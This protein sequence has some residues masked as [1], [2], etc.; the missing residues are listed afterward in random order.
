MTWNIWLSG[1]K[2]TRQKSLY[3]IFCNI[4]IY[5]KV[6]GAQNLGWTPMRRKGTT[7]PTTTPTPSPHH[8]PPGSPWHPRRGQGTG[9]PCCRTGASSRPTVVCRSFCIIIIAKAYFLKKWVQKHVWWRDFTAT[10]QCAGFEIVWDHSLLFEDAGDEVGQESQVLLLLLL[11]SWQGGRSPTRPRW[12]RRR[13]GS[14]PWK[15]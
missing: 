8:R 3:K 11:L 14:R 2:F 1:F 15:H 13:W 9:A 4:L 10:R 12:R 5:A 7:P 6:T